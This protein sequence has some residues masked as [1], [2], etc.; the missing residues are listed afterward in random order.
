MSR[1]MQ[2]G[3]PPFVQIYAEFQIHAE[4][5]GAEPLQKVFDSPQKLE[6]KRRIVAILMS[7]AWG[8]FYPQSLVAAIVF[9]FSSSYT[10]AK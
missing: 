10:L 6:R 5:G 1:G 9:C 7:I 4:F 3:G 2:K 8:I